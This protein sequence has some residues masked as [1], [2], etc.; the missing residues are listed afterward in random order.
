MTRKTTRKAPIS[1]YVL[2]VAEELTA[3]GWR[4][5]ALCA[6]ADPEVFYP[7]DESWSE[8]AKRVCAGCPVAAQCLAYALIAGEPHGVWGGLTTDERHLVRAA[9]ISSPLDSAERAA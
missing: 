4:S 8:P 6:Q 9:L 5:E 3:E 1:A 2:A 7:V